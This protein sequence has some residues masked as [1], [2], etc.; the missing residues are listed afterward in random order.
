MVAPVPTVVLAVMATAIDH[1]W[2]AI[3]NRC[4]LR[5]VN[6]LRLHIN[7]PRLY[8]HHLRLL[9]HHLRVVMNHMRPVLNRR[10][11]LHPDLDAG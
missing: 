11:I 5:V 9:V 10:R 7:G 6:R 4:R 2:G 1:L 8:V 3:V